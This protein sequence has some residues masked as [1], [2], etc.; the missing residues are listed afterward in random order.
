MTD[1]NYYNN[2]NMQDK[3]LSDLTFNASFLKDAITFIKSDRLNYSDEDVDTFSAS[4]LTDKVLE[5]M[6][7]QSMNERTMYKDYSFMADDKTPKGEKEAFTRLMFA[8]DNAKGEGMFDRGGEAIQDYAGAIFSSPTTLAAAAAGM[9]TGGVGALAVKAGTEIFKAGA[10][11][12]TAA[13]LRKAGAGILKR[14]LITAAADGSVAAGADLANQRIRQ[15]GG[16]EIGE[17]RDISLTQAAVSGGLGA[18]TGAVFSGVPALAKAKRSEVVTKAVFQGEEAIAGKRTAAIELAKKVD[19]GK[20]NGTPEQKALRKY[21]AST[22]LRAIDPALVKAGNEVKKDVFSTDLPDGIIGGMDIGTLQVLS[23]AALEIAEELGVTVASNGTPRKRITEVLADSISGGDGKAM[24]VVDR[25]RKK[26]GL[27]R[28]EVGAAYAAEISDAARVLRLARG[29]RDKFGRDINKTNAATYADKIEKLYQQGMSP[30]SKADLESKVLEERGGLAGIVI[31]TFKDAENARRMFMTSQPATTMRNNIFSVAM[32]GI[33]VVDQIN[34]AIVRTVRGGE[35]ISASNTF[36]GSVDNLKMLTNDAVVAEALVSMLNESAPKRMSKV[37]FDAAIAENALVKNNKLSKI[38]V[39][40]NILNTMSDRVVKRGIIAGSINRQLRELGD[41]DMGVNVLDMMSKGNTSMLSDDMIQEAVDEAM[42][43]TFQRN[44]GGKGA[45]KENKAVGSIVRAI[46]DYGLTL[47]IPFP[48]YLASQA[49]FVSDYTGLTVLRR[50]AT[51][52]SIADKEFAKTLTGAMGMYGLYNVYKQKVHDNTE[53]F[54]VTD[55]TSGNIYNAQSAMGP[56][57]AQAYVMDYFARW[58]EGMPTKG[59]SAFN[60]DLGRILGAT[61][62]RPNAGVIDSAIR[63]FEGT[64]TKGLKRTF[65]DIA[66]PITYPVAFFKDFYGQFDPRSAYL[67]NIEDPSMT[68]TTGLLAEMNFSM[69]LMQRV[70]RQLPDFNTDVMA[71]TFNEMFN[72]NIDPDGIIKYLEFAST[73]TRTTFQ[74]YDEKDMY[75]NDLRY[76]AISMDITGDGPRRI[77]NPLDKQLTGFSGAPRKNKF[78][79]EL[80]RLQI[81]AFKDIYN[82]YSEKNRTLELFF[83]QYAQG[84][85]ADSMARFIDSADYQ[86]YDDNSKKLAL[87]DMSKSIQSIYKEAAKD[88]MQRFAN[89]QNQEAV[90]KDFQSYV[91]AE[92]GSLSPK[93]TAFADKSWENSRELYNPIFEQEDM[94]INQALEWIKSDAFVEFAGDE[95]LEESRLVY[96]T[97]A[98]IKY[99]EDGALF[100][101]SVKRRSNEDAMFY[102]VP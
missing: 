60:K 41:A 98:M 85:F 27:S 76:D 24:E 47:A 61:E 1:I 9:F 34:T 3:K 100:R 66:S 49:K 56:L 25:I 38:G 99:F 59:L 79:S 16:K 92:F 68:V 19:A 52:R 86:S 58:S 64:D 102:I 20:R 80:T 89:P 17:E 51:G 43:F 13:T 95:N 7:Y 65:A 23:S 53:W 44:F 37:F 22:M 26:Y 94:D 8:F 6:R 87:L 48:K 71:N 5:H 11:S 84:R 63:A 72:T 101:A 33:D 45:S 40:T 28:E 78:Q 69:G 57:T 70:T 29:N 97:N 36:K 82:P 88:Q 77:L 96:S 91:R 14:S 10:K 73:A 12:V 54:E 4:D 2:E 30:L 62:F 39:A 31:R 42:A 74:R 15:I 46:H 83:Q 50:A 93:E 55:P 35:G 67:A 81:D 90:R 32:A 18:A 75:S 21:I